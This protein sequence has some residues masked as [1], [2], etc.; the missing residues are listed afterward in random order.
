MAHVHPQVKATKERLMCSGRGVCG[1]LPYSQAQAGQ[2]DCFEGFGSSDGHGGIGLHE[3][4]GWPKVVVSGCPGDV[5]CS[6]HGICHDGSDGTTA[7]FSCDC[8]QGFTG[9]DCS[10]R[11]CP[12]GPLWFVYPAANEVRDRITEG[13]C[14]G[15]G[16]CDYSTGLCT[17]APWATG[18]ACE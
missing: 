18:A 6:G 9:G 8:F 1:P 3:D 12:Q 11:L 2:C 16:S 5:S 10:L 7:T 13:E 14:S 17:C 4:C 15:A